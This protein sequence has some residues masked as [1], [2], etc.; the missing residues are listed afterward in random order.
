MTL[1]AV[2]LVSKEIRD[3]METHERGGGG[4]NSS[5]TTTSAVTTATTTNN[6][7]D[8][9]ERTEDARRSHALLSVLL[10]E[11]LSNASLSSAPLVLA[12]G[13]KLVG[14]FATLVNGGRYGSSGRPRFGAIGGGG[15]RRR[16]GGISG[17]VGDGGNEA[18]AGVGGGG[19]S[20]VGTS[21]LPQALRYLAAGLQHEVSRD[22]AAISVRTLASSC[23]RAI[24]ADPAALEALLGVGNALLSFFVVVHIYTVYI[25]FVC[26]CLICFY[27]QYNSAIFV[28]RDICIFFLHE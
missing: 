17:G 6:S 5:S 23:E 18:E 12:A 2:T 1:L 11:L 14:S 27:L 20:G 13:C 22:R 15:G 3:W 28:I 16:G 21:L 8:H 10:K 7:Q 9:Q 26:F 24:V 19:V 25:Y 4:G